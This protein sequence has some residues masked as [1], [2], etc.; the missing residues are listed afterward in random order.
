MP[1]PSPSAL[2]PLTVLLVSVNV[3]TLKMPPPLPPVPPLRIVTPLMFTVIPEP[4]TNTLLLGRTLLLPSMMVVDAPPPV[5]VRLPVIPS[6][7]TIVR[8][9]VFGGRMISSAPARALD[10]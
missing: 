2:F 4:A 8:R 3:P 7:V 9:Y 10:S 6:S 5:I 1:P